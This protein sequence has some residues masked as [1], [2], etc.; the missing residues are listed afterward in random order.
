LINQC[1]LF[2]QANIKGARR[3]ERESAIKKA[4]ASGSKMKKRHR[5]MWAEITNGE[6]GGRIDW[7]AE[8]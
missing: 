5:E 3:I 4:R 7:Q 1:Y 8:R 2:E 6:V